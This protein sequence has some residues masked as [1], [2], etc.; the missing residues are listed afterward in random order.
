MK[1]C[2]KCDLEMEHQEAEPD[3][4]VNGG[5]YC[6]HCDISYPD[7]DDYDQGWDDIS[8]DEDPC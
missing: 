6:S 1:R 8:W 2:P 5:W 3:V 7:W 4:G